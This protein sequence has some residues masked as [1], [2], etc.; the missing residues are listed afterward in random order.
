MS[1]VLQIK[2]Y[3]EK[4]APGF[5]RQPKGTRAQKSLGREPV[6]QLGPMG[7][8]L[9]IAWTSIQDYYVSKK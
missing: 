2:K 3:P 5:T 1:C 9:P 6:V 7:G 8:S 4:E